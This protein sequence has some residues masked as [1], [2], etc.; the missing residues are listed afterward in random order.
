MN[1]RVVIIVSGGVADWSCDENVNV[2]LIDLDNI[3]N[4]TPEDMELIRINGY[5][6]LIPDYVKRKYMST[7]K[8]ADI[9]LRFGDEVARDMYRY[10][11]FGQYIE[12]DDC[13]SYGISDNEIFFY[14]ESEDEL[15]EYMKTGRE[16]LITEYNLVY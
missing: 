13:D 16:F 6:D 12:D 3:D 9:T 7:P 11:S 4:A 14:F 1:N 2:C 5:E 10:A 8:G 15:K